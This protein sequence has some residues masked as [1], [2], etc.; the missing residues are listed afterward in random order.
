MDAFSKPSECENH[1]RVIVTLDR[2]DGSSSQLK[3]ADLEE[4]DARS[5]FYAMMESNVCGIT[6]TKDKNLM[7][8]TEILNN[9]D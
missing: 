6:I 9:A 2:Y 5:L 1:M 4:I 3:I 7:T 8:V